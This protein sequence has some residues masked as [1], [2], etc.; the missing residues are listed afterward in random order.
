M[1]NAIPFE[2]EVVLTLP[3]E[4]VEALNEM[5]PNGK[6]ASHTN[7]NVLKKASNSVPRLWLHLPTRCL[8]KFKTIWSTPSMLAIT[9]CYA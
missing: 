9:A 6:S 1:R 8:L 5:V 3:K 7:I 2:C 4:N